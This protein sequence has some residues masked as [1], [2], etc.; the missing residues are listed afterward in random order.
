LFAGASSESL[1]L[2]EAAF[3]TG[4]WTGLATAVDLTGVT[5]A[6]FV[7]SSSDESESDEVSCFFLFARLADDGVAP[8]VTVGVT[9]AKERKTSKCINERGYVPFDTTGFLF[10]GAS[11][12]SLLLDEA[13]FLTGCWAGFVTGVDLTVAFFF[14]LSSDESESDDESFFLLA[15][16]LAGGGTAA[17]LT[18][19]EATTI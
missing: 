3:L 15:V 17:F 16:R 4:C 12:E 5:G 7:L 14:V 19:D 1:L 13:T 6:F 2:D 18:G 10:A 9:V 11:S 8:F